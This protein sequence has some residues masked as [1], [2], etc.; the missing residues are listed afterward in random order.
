MYVIQLVAGSEF[1]NNYIDF[2]IVTYSR[3]SNSYMFKFFK[4][5]SKI[6]WTEVT[7]HLNFSSNPTTVQYH[8]WNH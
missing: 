8:K 3:F 2:Q 1:S 4:V 6:R 7:W 5:N